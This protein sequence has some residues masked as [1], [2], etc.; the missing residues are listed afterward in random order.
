MGTRTVADLI[1]DLFLT[2]RKPNG[3]E[4]STYDVAHGIKARGLGA[5]TPSY[6]A[7]LRRGE[8]KNPSREVLMQLCMF[9]E[10]PAAYFF[11]ELNHLVERLMPT[12]LDPMQQARLA[13]RSAGLTADEQA[14]LQGLFE[15]LRRRHTSD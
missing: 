1:N 11:P 3:Q 2:H 9:F 6:I 12:P 10:T 8:A 14:H 13:F 5:I 7:K 4:Y 15:L